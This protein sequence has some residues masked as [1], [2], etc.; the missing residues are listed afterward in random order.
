MRGEFPGRITIAED[1]HKNP[2]ITEDNQDGAGF[3]AQWDA[4]FVHPVRAE[5]DQLDDTHRSVEAIAEAIGHDYGD[6]AERVIYTESHDE[7]A[8]GRARVP[9]ETCSWTTRLRPAQKRS[10][11]G[12]ALVMT[13]PGI[14]MMFQ[15]RSSWRVAGSATTCRWTGAATRT[16]RAAS[17]CTP[18]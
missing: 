18:T 9:Q 4:A 12:A 5:P 1:L 3:H 6:P 13:S 7:V 10:T 11:I 15:A 17:G 16:S 8:N 2:L 14:P